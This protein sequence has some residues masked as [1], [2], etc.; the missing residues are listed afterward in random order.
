[1]SAFERAV[2]HD[3]LTAIW[4]DKFKKLSRSC[5]G[6]DRVSAEK[7][8]IN[9]ARE[10][11]KIR[12]SLFEESAPFASDG[13]LGL[14]KKKP[15]SDKYRIICVPTMADR[16]IQFALLRT[17]KS[18]LRPMGLDNSVSF[19]IAEG[20]DRGV[21]GARTFACNARDQHPWVYKTD[22]EQFFDNIDREKLSSALTR[23]V[24]QRSLLKYLEVFLHTEITEGFDREWRTIVKENGIHKGRGIRQGMPLSPLLAG[25]YLRDFDRL[26]VK[27]K[28]PVARY[29]DDII[30]F[31]D[32]EARARDFHDRLSDALT[33]I[34]LTLGSLDLEG[35]KTQII[36]PGKPAPFLGMEICRSPAGAHR[37]HVSADCIADCVKRIQNSGDLDYLTEKN[38]RLTGMAQYFRSIVNGYIHAYSEAQNRD[39]LRAAV[40]H[41]AQGAQAAILRQLFGQERLESLSCKQFEFLGVKR[42][43]IFK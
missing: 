43:Q 39:D 1:M 10:I 14:A 28:V 38:V 40:E 37:L 21:K 19:G 13:L 25:V 4:H 11:R 9:R 20:A 29:A 15:N 41:A 6:V 22:I 23:V 27:T 30:A 33:H 35:S 32:T 18:R 42:D 12:S 16:L 8:E 2:T 26:L 7:F 34:G 24:R 17:L 5:F 36:A 31:F 3:N